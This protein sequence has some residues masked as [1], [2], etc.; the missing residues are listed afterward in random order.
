VALWLASQFVC[1]VASAESVFC[2]LR[3]F[4]CWGAHCQQVAIALKRCVPVMPV[5]MGWLCSLAVPG[6]SKGSCDTSAS[7]ICCW[8]L[9]PSR[10]GRSGPQQPAFLPESATRMVP[11]SS[12][13]RSSPSS[14][15]SLR[16]LIPLE[17]HQH[18]LSRAD[19]FSRCLPVPPRVPGACQVI[20][21][22]TCTCQH[23]HTHR[24]RT[25]F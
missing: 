20:T 7:L 4:S 16:Y 6:C 2:T 19:L 1:E 3:G 24:V 9:A 22:H 25:G 8:H 15:R 21:S 11:S 13:A 10:E 17:S 23:T 18:L 14:P 12:S 5:G